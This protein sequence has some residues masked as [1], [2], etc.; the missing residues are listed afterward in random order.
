MRRWEKRRRSAVS[1]IVLGGFA[2][3]YGLL[4]GPGINI[5]LGRPV[6]PEF[7]VVCVALG[8]LAGVCGLLRLKGWPE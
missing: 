3:L 2:V 1:L 7:H 5:L 8:L 4:I 6:E